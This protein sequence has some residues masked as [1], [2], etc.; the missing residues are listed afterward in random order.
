MRID[1]RLD[2]DVRNLRQD[3]LNDVLP[4]LLFQ[5]RTQDVGV[6]A[7]VKLGL[8][9]RQLFGWDRLVLPDQLIDSRLLVTALPQHLPDRLD[10]LEVASVRLDDG[11]MVRDV[12]RPELRE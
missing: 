8:D 12:G 7:L 10:A 11:L 4:E 2:L 3:L 9:R 1:V 6:G 5:L